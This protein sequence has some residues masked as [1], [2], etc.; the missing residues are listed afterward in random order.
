MPNCESNNELVERQ[1]GF[2]PAFAEAEHQYCILIREGL[3]SSV[4][5]T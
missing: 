3:V 2:F 4:A 5:W 1:F